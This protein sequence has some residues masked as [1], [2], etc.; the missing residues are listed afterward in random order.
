MRKVFKLISH[1][2][3]KYALLLLII[4][5]SILSIINAAYAKQLSTLYEYIGNCNKKLALNA[6]IILVVLIVFRIIFKY[7]NF[8]YRGNKAENKSA[9]L[10]T[11]L[12][13]RCIK[14]NI[15][16]LQ[17]INI[18]EVINYGINA[19]GFVKD[20]FDS[21]TT[22]SS[23]IF[24]IICSYTIMLSTNITLSIIITILMII[25]LILNIVI[26]KIFLK[27]EKEKNNANTKVI[28]F[29]N[30]I[31]NYSIIKSFCR[32]N[33]ETEDMN[34]LSNSLKDISY[35]KRKI[36]TSMGISMG[37]MNGIT[38][39]TIFVYAIYTNMK[40][41]DIILFSTLFE[42]IFGIF[43]FFTDITDQI[44]CA[45][46]TSKK[47][48]EILSIENEENGTIEL[49]EFNNSIEFKDVSFS[50]KK[51]ENVL[52]NINIVI[53]K[54]KK[55]GIYGPSGEGKSTFINL[56]NKF[57]KV[58]K[59]AIY[60]DNININDITFNSLR[61]KIGIVS[62]DIY[63][64]DGT[65]E[66]N[67]RYGK[68]DADKEDIIRAAKKA[69]AY[70]FITK[71]K[72]GF[73]SNIGR[74]GIKLSGGQKQRISIA[75]M[76]LA[77][78]DIIILDEATSKLDNESEKIVQE[79]IDNFQDNKTVISIAHRLSTLDNCDYL[80]GIKNHIIYE[81]GTK[82]ELENNKDSLYY[83]LSNM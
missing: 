9:I 40:Y 52:N 83:K 21:A 46:T 25:L 23:V 39:I 81:Q 42:N 70:E 44:S 76:I 82:K 49:E 14:A 12:F 31:R 33:K 43:A 72:D 2:K 11:E 58:D 15:K 74:D 1:L 8:L 71:F 17:E 4:S 28:S 22:I 66:D 13:E 7:G 16:T 61:S 27:L 10:R 38:I 48:Y 50:Y 32:E 34:N 29:Y 79:A 24:D 54:G 55:I 73:N 59:G 60:I 35:H 65:I 75:R 51:S 53:P 62:Q 30:R 63:L 67:I 26:G 77:N 18:D 19:T 68:P 41:S 6:L 3:I 57:Y 36:N 56:I 45:Y 80:I 47:I 69:N 5:T 64:F 20:F 78:P 37:I